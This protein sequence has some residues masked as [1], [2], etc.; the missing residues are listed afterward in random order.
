MFWCVE[1][2]KSIQYVTMTYSF[3]RRLIGMIRHEYLDRLFFWSAV[4]LGRKLEETKIHHNESRC[5]QLLSG[6]TA[7]EKSGGPVA[8]PLR[9]RWSSRGPR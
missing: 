6:V 1:E 2:A 4:D 8:S 7:L 5:R 9:E 3:V